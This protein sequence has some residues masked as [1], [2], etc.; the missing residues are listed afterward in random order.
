VS[1]TVRDANALVAEARSATGLD[2]L[3]D[4]SFLEWLELLIES[5]NTDIDFHAGGVDVV[6]GTIVRSLTNRL[7]VEEWYRN[8]P[9]T[10]D[11]PVTGPILIT[12][13]PRSGTTAL[14]GMLAQDTSFRALR[15][16]EAAQPCPP[17]EVGHE[18]DDLRVDAARAMADAMPPEIV[19][20]HIVD[21]LGPEED[22]DILNLGFC[23]AHYGG[24][25]PVH[26]YPKAWLQ[27]DMT[28]AFAYH[29]RV[30]RL[31]GSRRPPH[32][33]LLKQPLHI[34]SLEAFAQRYPDARFVMTHRDPAKAIPSVC[35][36]MA[37][38]YQV[39]TEHVDLEQHG[40]F[41]LEFWSE[42]IS[43][44]LAA[45]GRIGEHRFVDV[46]HGDLV[47]DPEREITRIYEFLDR[48]PSDDARAAISAY[49]NEH[50]SEA[51]STHKYTAAEFGLSAPDIRA[52][53]SDY[54]SRFD[55]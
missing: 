47:R 20:M 32:D 41:Q 7:Q 5:A 39:V 18:D 53:F 48:A 46:V 27:A 26:R 17:P 52:A 49:I 29:E 35:S 36:L 34:F 40:R 24:F 42:G 1:G 9:E 15:G 37:W 55:L 23:A 25:W 4:E 19:A 22:H 51:A 6:E 38:S 45:R 16:W 11:T 12:G 8:H 13:L 30:L 33:W 21:P 10:D 43:R 14:V 50:R 28:A 3:G 31:L 44:A 54:V 2:N